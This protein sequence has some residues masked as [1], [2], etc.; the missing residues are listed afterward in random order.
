MCKKCNKCSTEY[1]I[2]VENH[3]HKSCKTKDGFNSTC[4]Y[5]SLRNKHQINHIDEDNNILCTKCLTYQSYNNFDK[6]EKHWYR[7]YRDLRCK[8]CK[9]KQ[10]LKRLAQNRGTSDIN[11]LL[12]K[13]YAGLVSRA[14]EKGLLVD[15]DKDFLHYLWE[16]Q[17]GLC[18]ITGIEMTTL[19]FKGRTLTNVSIDRIDSNKGYLKNN[20][21]LVCM[22][23]NQMKS[24]LTQEELLFFCNK[25]I[26]Y[27]KKNNNRKDS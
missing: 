17:K 26:K 20:T 5:C 7:E 16:K 10:Y 14:K 11:N 21:Q 8:E 24:N 4:K 27:E 13:R 3:F 19:V 22:V 6:N 1:C 15:F 18:A 12:S 23:I 25:I 2:E 9:N